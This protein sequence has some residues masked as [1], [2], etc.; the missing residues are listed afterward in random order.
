VVDAGSPTGAI[1]AWVASGAAA[2]AVA[3]F[4]FFILLGRRRRQNAEGEIEDSR[5]MP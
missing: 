3:L 4:L 5:R 2:L 1:G